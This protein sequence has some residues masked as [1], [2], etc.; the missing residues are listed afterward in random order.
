[1]NR[2]IDLVDTYDDFP[3]GTPPTP[4]WSPSQND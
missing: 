2:V 1:M 3:L 4:L